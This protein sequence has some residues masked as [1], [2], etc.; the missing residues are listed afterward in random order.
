MAPTNNRRALRE[1]NAWNFG[2]ARGGL[3]RAAFSAFR[4]FISSL[5]QRTAHA[6]AVRASALDS[7]PPAFV[8]GAMP[9]K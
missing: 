5:H 9:Q 4:L 3:A 7:E 8:I 2:S 1:R 6:I